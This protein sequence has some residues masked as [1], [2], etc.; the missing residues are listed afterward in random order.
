LLASALNVRYRDINFIVQSIL[1]VWFY[2]TPVVYT[3][4]MVPYKYYWLWRFN[5]MTSVLQF[6]QYG[7]LDK[8]LPG[9]AMISVNIF[10]IICIFI[11]GLLVFRKESVNFADWL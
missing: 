10:L 2:M 7:F 11:T 9:V 1:V 4:S 6:M 3:L 5:P 8:P